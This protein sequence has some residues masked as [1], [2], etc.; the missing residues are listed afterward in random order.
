MADP[1]IG[2]LKI[3]GG[4]FAP[5]GWMF[6]DG[7]LLAIS[8]YEA[9]FNL[10]GT[11]YGGD[12][13]STFAL[14]DLRGRIPLHQG[15]GYVMG[16]AAGVESVT[17]LTTQIPAHNHVAA[18]NSGQQ[19]SASAEGN[20]LS[21]TTGAGQVLYGPPQNLGA[22]AANAVGAT[23]GNQPHEN[24]QPSLVI[25]FIIAVEGIYPSVSSQG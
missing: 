20:L 14:P 9:L 15:A 11:T 24:I 8:E 3:F 2:E 25:N 16:Q 7:R 12:G 10:I 13:V 1:Y 21:A 6:C 23:G 22:F 17:L 5:V 18:A 4:N 19:S